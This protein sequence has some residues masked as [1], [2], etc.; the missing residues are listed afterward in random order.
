MEH[1]EEHKHGHGRKEN[2]GKDFQ[3]SGSRGAVILLAALGVHSILEM[4]ALGLADTFG[5]CSLLTL[6]IAL[7]QV[8]F[9]HSCFFHGDTMI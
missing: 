1:A 3:E 9:S 4:M 6:S 7:H 2:G 8:C 5:D